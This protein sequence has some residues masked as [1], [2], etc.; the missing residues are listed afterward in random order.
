MYTRSSPILH[1]RH[2]ATGRSERDRRCFSCGRHFRGEQNGQ[3]PGRSAGRVPGGSSTTKRAHISA[4]LPGG[5]R[6][7]FR[8]TFQALC[9]VSYAR[10]FCT[11]SGGVKRTNERS[12]A[13]PTDQVCPWHVLFCR[14]LIVDRTRARFTIT[15][16]PV[17]KYHLYTQLSTHTDGDCFFFLPDTAA[18]DFRRAIRP[19]RSTIIPASSRSRL[20]YFF[21]VPSE[22]ST[23]PNRPLNILSLTVEIDTRSLKKK[24]LQFYCIARRS[25]MFLDWVGG[26]P[27]RAMSRRETTGSRVRSPMDGMRDITITGQVRSMRTLFL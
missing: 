24:N 20:S 13:R 8:R 15:R 6:V 9:R 3:R 7:R 1:P 12:L 21:N 25:C 10:L 27:G 5:V 23:R 11:C 16:G 18:H 17:V 26:G 14:W 22:S 2:H 19:R 4:S